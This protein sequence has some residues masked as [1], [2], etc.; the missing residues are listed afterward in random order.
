MPV[1][2]DR[3]DC[4]TC[5]EAKIQPH[6]VF[7]LCKARRFDEALSLCRQEI[8]DRPVET[9]GYRHMAS[10]LEL[11][12]THAEAI[13]YRDKL[14]ELEPHF[15]ANYFSRADLYYGMGRYASAVRDFS[16]AA[17]LDHDRAFGSL[18]FLYRADCHRRLGDYDKAISDCALVPDDFEFPGFLG[19]RAGG[20]R[21]LLAQ[22]ARERTRR[23]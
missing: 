10:A 3:T 9:A 22:I 14:I 18:I 13:P 16:R 1:S 7:D 2:A 12:Q 8:A 20:K 23:S 5:S 11:M 4:R 15:A 17:E 6:P 19:Q 21:H